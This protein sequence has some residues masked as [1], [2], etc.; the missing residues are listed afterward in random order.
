MLTILSIIP[1]L[2][3]SILV[4]SIAMHYTPMIQLLFI[5][6][7]ILLLFAMILKYSN[8]LLVLYPNYSGF[9]IRPPP[10]HAHIDSIRSKLRIESVCVCGPGGG[11]M[12][13]YTL[14]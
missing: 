10:G 13:Y 12:Y 11:F 7:T 8:N 1:L 6:F 14:L 9:F 4:V 2:G 3:P 5:I